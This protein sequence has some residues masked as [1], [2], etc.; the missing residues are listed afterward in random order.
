M[1]WETTFED[2]PPV[3]WSEMAPKGF[4]GSPLPAGR[5]ETVVSITRFDRASGARGTH[6]KRSGRDFPAPVAVSKWNSRPDGLALAADQL[7]PP[8]AGRPRGPDRAWPNMQQHNRQLQGER[9][10]RAFAHA[11]TRASSA[12]SFAFRETFV[13]DQHRPTRQSGNRPPAKTH[14]QKQPVGVSTSIR[15]GEQ[16]CSSRTL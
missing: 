4:G 6:S 11:S 2:L 13:E 12:S 5:Q 3:I 15:C 14:L 9:G 7:Q 16:Q 8:A 10:T 1:Q